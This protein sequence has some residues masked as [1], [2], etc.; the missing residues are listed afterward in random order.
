MSKKSKYFIALL[1][2]L[3]IIFIL[4]LVKFLDISILNTKN[5]DFSFKQI[6]IGYNTSLINDNKYEVII[7]N[8][9][10][11]INYYQKYDLSIIKS[12]YNEKFFNDNSLAIL[13]IP[14]NSGSIVLKIDNITD[15][16]STLKIDYKL[17]L[18]DIRNYGYEWLF[19]NNNYW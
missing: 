14:L 6:K 4:Y 17:I 11:F 13:Y 1:V 15:N 19:S 5:N 12:K 3:F 9:N 8:Y 18:P 10:D 16:K 7:D 2:I